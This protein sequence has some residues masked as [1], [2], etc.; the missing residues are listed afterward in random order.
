MKKQ[1]IFNDFHPGEE[2]DLDFCT[3]PK[4]V[5][6]SLYS[7]RKGDVIARQEDLCKGLYILYKG[8]V[9]AEMIS[10]SGRVIRIEEIGAIKPLAPAFIFAGENRFPVDVTALAECEIIF[11]E[12]NELLK[13]FREESKALEKYLRYNSDMTRFLS[14]KLLMLSVKTIRGKLA[15][16][17]I[18]LFNELQRKSPGKAVVTMDKSQTEL[19]KYFGV[20]RPSLAREMAEME[21][22]RIIVFHRREVRVISL[23]KL[24]EA[25]G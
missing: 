2:I 3:I 7:Y 20:S 8:S 24:K 4:W 18:G 12:K 10:E 21:K 17:I 9:V 13:L 25:C 11:I 16:Y 1:G 6:C 14:E 22:D 23:S 5:S 19:A 15:H